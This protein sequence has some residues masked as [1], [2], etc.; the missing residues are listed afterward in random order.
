[1]T[2]LRRMLLAALGGFALALPQVAAGDAAPVVGVQ[3]MPL[4]GRTLTFRLPAG[5]VQA[6]NRN[7]GTNVLI[8]YVP[9]GET[10]E[11]WTRMVTIQAYRGLGSS[12]RSTA[13]IARQAFYP[14]ACRVGPIYRDGGELTIAPGL[15][16]SIVANGC[17]SLPPGAY[18]AALAGAGEQDFIMVFRDGQS[19]YTL[20]Y[21]LRGA[22]FAGKAPP[23]AP[24]QAEAQL[25]AVFGNVTL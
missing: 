17:A 21:A 24:N 12:P 15:K 22:A 11:N 14:A 19:I 3:R 16:R 10:V 6:L 7:N 5:F 13:D 18:P 23:I 1:M 8:E 20:N 25:H 9:R 4:L 2:T